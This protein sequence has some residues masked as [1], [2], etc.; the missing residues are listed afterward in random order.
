MDIEALKVVLSQFYDNLRFLLGENRLLKL[1]IQ[2]QLF[3]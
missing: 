2:L 3:I 1:V